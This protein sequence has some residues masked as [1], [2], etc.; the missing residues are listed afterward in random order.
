[1]F[2]HTR[3]SELSYAQSTG[4]FRTIN[5]NLVVLHEMNVLYCMGP[6]FKK[7]ALEINTVKI[8]IEQFQN[9]GG[10]LSGRITHHELTLHFYCVVAFPH[11]SVV[12]RCGREAPA[13]QPG[14]KEKGSA[15]STVCM[16][17]CVRVLRAELGIQLHSKKI[18]LLSPVEISPQ[19]LYLLT[20]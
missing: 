13:S 4:L 7:R 5:I 15:G 14:W 16:Y 12:Q 8:G 19:T 17:V 6:C 2:L 3:L 20:L 9:V 10:A 18:I 1:M 11:P